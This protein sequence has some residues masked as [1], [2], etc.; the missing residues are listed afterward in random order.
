MDNG[1]ACDELADLISAYVDGELSGE[2]SAV[3][4]RHIAACPG[5]ALVVA[6]TAAL[7]RQVR[8]AARFEAPA[9]L[10]ERINSALPTESQYSL[11]SALRAR[12]LRLVGSHVLAA[13]AG[14]LALF[15]WQ[16]D[17]PQSVPTGHFVSAHVRKL[18]DGG[19]RSV[20]SSDP[21][22]I[23]P[24]F[25]GKLPFAPPVIALD[26]AG[27]LLVGSYIDYID[28]Q[29]AAALSY[30]RRQHLI[31]LFIRPITKQTNGIWTD[32]SDHGYQGVS[33]HDQS[34]AYWAVSDLSQQELR[35]FSTRFRNKAEGRGAVISGGE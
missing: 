34:F 29:A 27:F 33:W 8:Q 4:A 21:H 18:L 28:D 11:F 22:R 14:A 26:D 20:D 19:L 2:D 35:D 16:V 12:H 6:R 23:R 30:K 1:L 25:A 15:M 9:G 13:T 10:P 5:C 31:T 3:V 32:S 24:W 7:S 17:I